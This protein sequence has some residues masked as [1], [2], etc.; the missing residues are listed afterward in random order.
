MAVAIEVKRRTVDTSALW[1][2]KRYL[3]H[4]EQDPQWKRGVRG[5]LVGPH[6]RQACKAHLAEEPD[7]TFCRL[8][9]DDL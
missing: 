7:I 9:F 5:V 6:L 1:Q 3:A 4:L 8:G 2:L